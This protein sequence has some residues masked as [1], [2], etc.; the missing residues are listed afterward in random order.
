MKEGIRLLLWGVLAAPLCLGA[1]ITV[2]IAPAQE[3]K[4]EFDP[5]AQVLFYPQTHYAKGLSEQDKASRSGLPVRPGQ[6]PEQY[7]FLFFATQTSVLLRKLTRANW[8]TRTVAL[9][10]SESPFA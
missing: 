3:F 4:L 1:Q 7:V 6:L 9:S 5:D 2:R 8:E 10:C